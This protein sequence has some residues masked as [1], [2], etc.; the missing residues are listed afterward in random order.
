MIQLLDS[1]L[2]LESLIELVAW[3]F[4]HLRPLSVSSCWMV[5]LAHEA[6]VGLLVTKYEHGATNCPDANMHGVSCSQPLLVTLRLLTEPLE[7][8]RS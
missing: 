3:R 5:K 2:T 7:L 8:I 4:G 1:G 6:V